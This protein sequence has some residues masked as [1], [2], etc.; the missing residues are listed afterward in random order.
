V[1][2]NTAEERHVGTCKERVGEPP[3]YWHFHDC[4]R[5]VKASFVHDDSRHRVDVCGVHA[6][7]YRRLSFWTEIKR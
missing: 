3:G 7:H 2:P 1:T 5:P 6:R 4:D